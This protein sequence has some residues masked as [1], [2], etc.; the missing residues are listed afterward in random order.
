MIEINPEVFSFGAVHIRWYGVMAACGL[1]AAFL[2]M[3][4]RA[5]KYSFT[6]DNV[7]DMLFWGMLS[8]IVGA[9]ALYVIRFW[10]EGFAGRPFISVFKV[11]EGGLV[12]FG[13]FCG[14]A[15][16][17][18][19][20]C[21]WRKWAIWKVADLVAPALALGHAFGRMGCLLNGC[22]YGF[23]Y[24]GFG[25]FRYVDENHGTFPLQLFSALGNVLICLALLFCEKKGW[26]KQKLFL[27]YMVMYNIGRFCIEFGRGDYPAEQRVWG[28]TPAQITC[29]WLLPAVCAVYAIVYF[30]AKR[31]KIGAASK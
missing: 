24:E 28:L 14:A 17:L 8:A 9:R 16:I 11:F 13:G 2:V 21:I 19:G 23:A 1:M 15:L 10:D 29:L 4:K 30:V 12:F 18:L 31:I 27:G 20:M 5:E 7:S 25:A 6:K 3:Q 22:C 26:L